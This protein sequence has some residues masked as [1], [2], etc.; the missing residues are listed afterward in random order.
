[1]MLSLNSIATLFY[2]CGVAYAFV[3]VYIQ[4]NG[5]ARMQVDGEEE[6]ISVLY[7]CHLTV[8]ILWVVVTFAQASSVCYV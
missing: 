8:S 7:C 6:L 4:E 2:Y 5:Q 3:Y 1:M